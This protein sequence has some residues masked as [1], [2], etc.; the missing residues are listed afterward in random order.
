GM[1]RG[2]VMVLAAAAVLV[3]SAGGFYIWRT[4]NSGTAQMSGPSQTTS[5]AILPFRNASGDPSLDW[6]SGSLV[7]MLRTDIGQ[8]AQLH[9]VPSNRLQEMLR[10]LRITSGAG[11]DSATL[12]RL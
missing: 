11:F 2:R 12:Q 1:S 10:D 7:E 9:I 3:V 6:R 5:L 4:G 8:S